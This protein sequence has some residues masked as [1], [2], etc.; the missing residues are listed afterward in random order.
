MRFGV[1][2][3]D[4]GLSGGPVL[5]HAMPGTDPDAFVRQALRSHDGE[6]LYLTVDRPPQRIRD[7][8]QALDIQALHFLDAH[9]PLLGMPPEGHGVD[10]N[11]PMDLVQALDQARRQHPNALLVLDGLGSMAMRNSERFTA[12][13]PRLLQAARAFPDVVGIFTDWGVTP[14]GLRQF[15]DEIQLLAVEERILSHTYFR[16]R[17]GDDPP[18]PMILYR[19]GPDGVRAHVPKVVIAGP[20][21][22]GRTAFV[23]GLCGATAA[24]RNGVAVTGERGTCS[25][26]GMDVEIFGAPG[27]ARFDP[28][29]KRL[30]HNA[31]G[32]VLVV[33]GSG[34][35][36][37]QRA[38][39]ILGLVQ[40][41]GKQILVVSDT[42]GADAID[43][44]HVATALGLTDATP[45]VT[46]D[47]HDPRAARDALGRLMMDLLGGTT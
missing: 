44:E 10:P 19:D 33:D 5:V 16:L 20:D 2:V 12:A 13:W 37:F 35:G 45:V 1:P 23:Q 4:H 36:G 3:L 11:N 26:D 21:F 32:V 46:C 7:R 29:T 30:L 25:L 43:A 28:L 9:S 24:Q 41:S 34:R 38:K 15:G 42:S 40:E 6:V 14:P 47:V 27:A 31:F 18:G 8:L 39:Q 22:P 17:H